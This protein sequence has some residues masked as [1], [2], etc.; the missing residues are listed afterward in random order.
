MKG[1]KSIAVVGA[2]A[3]VAMLAQD[4]FTRGRMYD[5]K[6]GR[7]LQRDFLGYIDGMSLYQY[8]GSNPIVRT[9]P[10]GG[11]SGS[12][13]SVPFTPG[14][15]VVTAGHATDDCG[16]A[17]YQVQFSI[18]AAFTTQQGWIVQRVDTKYDV[19]DCCDRQLDV[20]DRLNGPGETTYD[21]SWY[22]KWEA[23]Q[24]TNGG[25]VWVGWAAQGSPHVKDTFSA[26][27]IGDRSKGTLVV[28]GKVKGIT[29]YALPS[30]FQVGSAGGSSGTLPDTTT[31]PPGWDQ[32]G[33]GAVHS[34]TVTWG[35]CKTPNGGVKQR[36]EVRTTP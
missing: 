8:V 17:D 19:K 20:R 22:P 14:I 11:C 12:S 24:F 15:S 6:A 32:V 13:N 34:M 33:G 25:N 3:L 4:G 2:I 23:W 27:D 1:T 31:M 18:P 29:N 28:S 16:G 30:D 26:L 35:C 9:D 10:T 7:F 21:P 5:P 36:T